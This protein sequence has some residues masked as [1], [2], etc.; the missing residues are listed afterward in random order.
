M[1]HSIYGGTV[2]LGS[3]K[4]GPLYERSE[5]FKARTLLG[6]KRVI[7]V[8]TLQG[9]KKRARGE[10]LTKAVGINTTRLTFLHALKCPLVVD[11]IIIVF[12]S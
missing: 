12:G 1:G 4:W 10:G 11:K 8:R 7:E 9:A 5:G 3:L 6:V 2:R